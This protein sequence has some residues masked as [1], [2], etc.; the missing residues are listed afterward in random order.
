[1]S[2]KPMP[3]EFYLEFVD[4][5]Y[6]APIGQV[7]V[8]W[9]IMEHYIENAIWQAAGT[10]VNLGRSMTSQTQIQ[11]KLDILSTLLYEINPNFANQFRLVAR[12]IRECLLGKRNLI[13]HGFWITNPDTNRV[14]VIKMAA[15]GKLISKSRVIP[16]QEVIELSHDIADV[17]S[18]VDQ[19]CAALPRLR[20]KRAAPNH[21]N[22]SPQT[23]PNC[24]ILKQQALQ[25]LAQP[26]KAPQKKK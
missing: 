4:Y 10:P 22:P 16:I 3:K 26:P 1:M 8:Q 11:S 23:P 2:K 5:D 21:K 19:L 18:W 6:L 17:T 9:S 12:Y 25:H 15:K 14:V 24:P 20:K 13:T 7:M